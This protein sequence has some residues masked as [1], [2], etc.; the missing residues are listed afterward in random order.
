MPG[1]DLRKLEI[2][3]M[4]VYKDYGT[5]VLYEVASTKYVPDYEAE[6]EEKLTDENEE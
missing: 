6:E 5:D 1:G 4:V 3:A 2:T